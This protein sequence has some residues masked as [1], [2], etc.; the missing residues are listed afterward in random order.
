[1]IPS[2]VVYG[3]AVRD[4]LAE[5]E[6]KGDLDIS[7]SKFE[8][9]RLSKIFAYHPK[10]V[11]IENKETLRLISRSYKKDFIKPSITTI[12]AFENSANRKLQLISAEG[13]VSDNRVESAITLARNVDLICCG[14]IMDSSG[15]VFEVV[16]DAF[17][18][19]KERI[20]KVNHEGMVT[21]FE[22]L[23][24]RVNKL[25]SRGWKLEF[26]VEEEKAKL[27]KKLE[28]IRRAK[29]EERRAKK[30][31]RRPK[32]EL[33]GQLRSRLTVDDDMV[34]SVTIE[35]KN[36]RRTHCDTFRFLSKTV[37][38]KIAARDVRIEPSEYAGLY[39]VILHTPY[40]D[41]IEYSSFL[42]N[43]EQAGWLSEK[44]HVTDPLGDTRGYIYSILNQEAS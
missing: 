31:L 14:L 17:N 27:R 19:C 34:H 24:E 11:R 22:N 9:Q 30:R 2:S 7:V 33:K 20:L 3:G 16:P 1:L 15:R 18:H 36:G 21:K 13:S 10:W 38:I 25:V 41:E 42:V 28:E 39:R 12:V 23:D 32:Y 8:F 6:L 35:F 40:L 29:E 26:D 37:G 43:G 44:L 5:M 4:T